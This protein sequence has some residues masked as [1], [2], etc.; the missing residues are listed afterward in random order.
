MLWLQGVYLKDLRPDI[1]WNVW[2]LICL[3]SA[4]H[5]LRWVSSNAWFVVVL[6]GHACKHM[7]AKLQV[8][9]QFLQIQLAAFLPP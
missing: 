7:R 8:C 2:T 5:G 3:V 4:V 1:C 6:Y 9:L